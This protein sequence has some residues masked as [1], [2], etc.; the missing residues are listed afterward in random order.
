MTNDVKVTPPLHEIFANSNQFKPIRDQLAY[1]KLI[2]PETVKNL[3]TLELGERQMILEPWF[4]KGGI[5]MVHAAAGV[6]KT[7]FCLNVAYAIANGGGFLTYTAPMPKKV[8]YVDAEMDLYSI[9]ERLQAIVKQQ[10]ELASD[11]DFYLLNPEK[12]TPHPIPKISN[13]DDQL[14]YE[15][16]IK[17]YGFEVIVFDNLSCLSDVD[18]NKAHEW[19]IVQDWLVKLRSRGLSIILVHHSGKNPLEQRGTSKRVDICDT[20]ISLQGYELPDDF[21]KRFKI[22]YQKH[23]SVHG[24]DAE[25]IEVTLR[26]NGSWDYRALSLS[27]FE[28]IVEM[29]NLKIS[30]SEISQEM[31]LSRQYIYK[32]I[33]KAKAKN[34][35]I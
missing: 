23:R 17:E 32:T 33:Q 28:K 22:V 7:L 26:E 27:N 13:T 19:R 25:S 5:C 18:E 4:P 11:Q 15:T 6:G 10:G 16:M 21:D 8:L 12:I 34:L 24:I 3:Y 9:Q 2:K 29:A 20:V 35:I 14:I 1:G 31:G 30:P